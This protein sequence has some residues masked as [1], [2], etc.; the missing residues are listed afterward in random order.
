MIRFSALGCPKL[1]QD[2]EIFGE[3]A[4]TYIFFELIY[5]ILEQPKFIFVSQET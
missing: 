1:I 5:Q 2:G 3:G 4:V